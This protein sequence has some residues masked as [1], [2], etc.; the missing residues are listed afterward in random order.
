[1]T[2]WTNPSTEDDRDL[3]ALEGELQEDINERAASDT[4]A[5]PPA[6][7]LLEEARFWTRIMREHA[8][9]IRLGLPATQ[10][11]D[12]VRQAREFQR[13]FARLEAE[14][15]SVSRLTPRLVAR[16]KRAV[17]AI[18]KYKER[19]LRLLIACRLPGNALYPLLVDHIRR[20]AEHF[21]ALL[22]GSTPKS[23]LEEV[24]L[25]EVFWLRIQK[26]HIEFVKGL[27]D[28]SERG[29]IEQ[30]EQFRATFSRLLETARDF[31]SMNAADPRS[32][33]AVR[34]FTD[35]VIT[36]TRALRDFEAAAY[37]L[38]QR[39]Q[40]LSIIPSPLLADHIRREADKF[41][42]ELQLLRPAEP[43]A[44]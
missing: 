5:I 9:F 24:L 11:P 23:R 29:L 18:V 10:R 25:T 13:I 4:F 39:C 7:T 14:V 27:L 41:L 8:I 42:D 33:N 37:E 36:A 38:L 43:G 17:R 21:L 28:P 6:G 20:E 15:N 3:L 40:V 34:R 26:E 31:A 22:T 2:D 16:L 32:F 12:L 19:I 30:T 35:E 44:K 1:M